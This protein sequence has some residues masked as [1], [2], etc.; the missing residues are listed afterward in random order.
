[1]E[2]DWDNI[3]RLSLDNSRQAIDTQNQFDCAELKDDNHIATFRLLTNVDSIEHHT[4]NVDN[5]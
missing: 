1:M 3:W 5:L 2:N 4:Q